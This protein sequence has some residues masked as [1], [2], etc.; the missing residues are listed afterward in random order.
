[1]NANTYD[2][3]ARYI[4]RCGEIMVRPASFDLW[5]Q[6]EPWLAEQGRIA[7]LEVMRASLLE[8]D[9]EMA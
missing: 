2:R 6:I 8:R 4:R 5:Q 9:L 7:V 1:V 3:Y